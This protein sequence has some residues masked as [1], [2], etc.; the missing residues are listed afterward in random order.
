MIEPALSMS[1]NLRD[2]LAASNVRRI[3]DP[4][5]VPLRF[6]H[7]KAMGQSAAHCFNSFQHDERKE[8]L[9]LRLGRGV[10]AMMFG[11]PVVKWEGK[12]RN[13]K[14]WDAFKADNAHAAILSASEHRTA[15]GI[16]DA[17]K[18]NEIA[19]GLLFAPDS[20]LEQPILWEQFGRARRSTPDARGVHHLIDL[21]TTRCAEPGRFTRDA[22]FRAYHAQLADYRAAME[23]ENGIKPTDCYVI[24][25]E[26]CQ[27][28]SVTT[29]KLT[30][31]ALDKGDRLLRLWFEQLRQCEEANA[32]P[33]YCESVTDFDV[34]DDDLGL[35]F[36]DDDEQQD[37]GAGS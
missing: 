16:V 36:G 6:H 21:K 2:E 27:P 26:S 1:G 31:R 17:L 29:L 24:A 5:T 34:P 7:L 23:S 15:T 28:Y 20:K 33:G 37:E 25:V 11:Q 22:M 8:G 4:R 18:N 30:E 19:A 14:V 35:V 32:W 3:V 9:P 12:T 10:H 13:G